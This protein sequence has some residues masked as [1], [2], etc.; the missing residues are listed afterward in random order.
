MELLNYLNYV[1]ELLIWF[2]REAKAL[3]GMIFL[4][5]NINYL[6]YLASDVRYNRCFLDGTS[7]FLFENYLQ[8]LKKYMFRNSNKPL[9][10]IVKCI[11]ELGKA[12][13]NHAQKHVLMGE[14]T[15]F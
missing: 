12:G 11:T 9:L 3:Y 15:F 14:T 7:A 1:E 5:Y 10:Q 4:S 8:I 13:T 6:I 2:S